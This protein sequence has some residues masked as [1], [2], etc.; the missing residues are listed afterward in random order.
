MQ[1]EQ[2]NCDDGEG[3]YDHEPDGFK[4]LHVRSGSGGLG[5][6]EIPFPNPPQDRGVNSSSPGSTQDSSASKRDGNGIHV[7][8]PRRLSS[9]GDMGSRA[10]FS[11]AEVS[12]PSPKQGY[13]V[14]DG[15]PTA[16]EMGKLTL[17]AHDEEEEF[18]V[19]E[20]AT[21]YIAES[22]VIAKDEA[23]LNN[24]GGAMRSL[25]PDDDGPLYKSFRHRG[26]QA[27]KKLP[28]VVES[29]RASQSSKLAGD[30]GEVESQSSHHSRKSSS[31][32]RDRFIPQEQATWD[33]DVDVES[34]QCSFGEDLSPSGFADQV[35]SR[36]VPR[37]SIATQGFYMTEG[38]PH[39]PQLPMRPPNVSRG[40]PNLGYGPGGLPQQGNGGPRPIGR[41]PGEASMMR[42]PLEHNNGIMGVG[43]QGFPP[44][45]MQ[46]A[47]GPRP[48]RQFVSNQQGF[49][50]VRPRVQHHQP[51][52]P[53]Q[54]Q[55][56]PGVRP[57]PLFGESDPQT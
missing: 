35:P 29:P 28:Q 26:G 43:Y 24:D 20:V 46:T 2:S 25:T 16:L 51:T 3:G 47:Q 5:H 30:S 23:R 33:R 34:T 48:Q 22:T 40:G 54:P 53:M 38:G 27:T 56:R 21:T 13:S 45:R 44:G 14:G 10:D 19:E 52:G 55:M 50:P 42:P 36:M 4:D 57:R 31:S 8:V 18:Q 41:G 12:S 17:V 11:F 32:Q 39:H 49:Q 1:H 9:F 37:D 7:A 15:I 6:E